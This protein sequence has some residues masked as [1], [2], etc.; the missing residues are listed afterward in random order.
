[1]KQTFGSSIYNENYLRIKIKLTHA[2]YLIYILVHNMLKKIKL[3]SNIFF[4]IETDI[5]LFCN[6]RFLIKELFSEIIYYVI[7]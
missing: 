6:N 5:S 1:M 3:L 4:T 7:V 2:R